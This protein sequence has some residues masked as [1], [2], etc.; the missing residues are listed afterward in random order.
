[1]TSANELREELAAYDGK[2]PTILSEIAV[3]HRGGAR[4]LTELVA[5]ASDVEPVI[6]A[7]AT[8]IIKAELERGQR[9]S[10]QDVLHLASSLDGVTAWQAQLHICQSIGR[11]A[12]PEEAAPALE[13]WLTAL[14]NAPRPFVR[15]WALD[16]LCRLRGASVETDALLEHM[17]KDKAASV[18]ARVR[19]LKRT[20]GGG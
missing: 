2:S 10:P 12:V 7:G 20:V 3:R 18:R 16:A 15:A 14:L 6:S 9:L 5:L 8:W 19:N 4:F 17:E 11:V 13:Q 1:M